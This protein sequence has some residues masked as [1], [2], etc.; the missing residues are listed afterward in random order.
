MSNIYGYY[1]LTLPEGNYTVQVTYIG[2]TTQR[3][4]LELNEDIYKD[5][6]LVPGTTLS[7]AVV[8]GNKTVKIED[9]VQMSKVEIPIDQIK[10]FLQLAEK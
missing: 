9:Q 3:I 7:E 6:N 10:D 8:T 5:F 2:Y 1:S 4:E